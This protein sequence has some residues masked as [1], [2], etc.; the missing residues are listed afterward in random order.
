[1]VGCR[2]DIVAVAGAGRNGARVCHEKGTTKSKKASQQ[3]HGV[4]VGGG[5]GSMS[6]FFGELQVGE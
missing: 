6:G 3:V 2:V 5:G 1:M 4:L